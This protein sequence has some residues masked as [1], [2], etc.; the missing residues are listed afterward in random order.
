MDKKLTEI[1]INKATPTITHLLFADDLFLFCQAKEREISQLLECLE[2][3]CKWSGQTMNSAKFSIFFSHNT[4]RLLRQRIKTLINLKTMN[5]DSRYLGL[6]ILPNNR[7]RFDFQE[8]IHK[9]NNKLAGWK[10]KTLSYAGR[11]TLIN[12]S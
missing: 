5:V 9:L 3:Y 6:P 1:K 11:A 10:I 12:M 2:C 8:I 4:P 7:G